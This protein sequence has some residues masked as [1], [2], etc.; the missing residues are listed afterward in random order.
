LLAEFPVVHA[1]IAASSGSGP[2]SVDES[3]FELI[4]ENSQIS[5]IHRFLRSLPDLLG[6]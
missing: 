5:R 1:A 6:P 4:S 2:R 3:A